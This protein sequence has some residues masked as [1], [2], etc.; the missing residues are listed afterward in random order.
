[1]KWPWVSRGRFEDQREEIERLRA[2]LQ[3]AHARIDTLWNVMLL[4]TGGVIVDPGSLPD[5]YKP[6][7]APEA[8]KTETKPPASRPS[9]QAIRKTLANFEAT[10]ESELLAKQGRPRPM[11]PEQAAVIADLNS[12]ANEAQAS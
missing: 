10:Q 11:P 7:P 9:P 2:E 8:P 1:M 5:V 6:K 12:A 3:G 4:R